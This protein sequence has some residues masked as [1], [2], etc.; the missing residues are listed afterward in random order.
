MERKLAAILAA[1]VVGYSRMIREDEETT[2]ATLAAHR[3]VFDALIAQ[4]NGRIFNTAG[5]SV[6]AEFA[7]PVEAVRCALAVQE[8]LATRNED[9]DENRKMWFRMGVNLGDV[10][11]N[12]DDLLGDGVNI[13]ARLESLSEPGGVCISNS[14]REQIESKLSFAFKD[15][16][17]QKVKNIPQPV[18]AY[19]MTLAAATLPAGGRTSGKRLAA[20]VGAGAVLAAIAALGLWWTLDDRPKTGIARFDGI[21]QGE[22]HCE[23]TRKLGPITRFFVARINQGDLAIDEGRPGMLGHYSVRG[24]LD[25]QGNVTAKGGGIGPIGNYDVVFSGSIQGDTLNVEAI[26]NNFRKCKAALKRKPE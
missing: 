2:I 8:A 19:Q 7:S 24:V 9:L 22:Y 11:I 26:H 17:D 16:G 14:V 20:I 13:A 10:L 4:H 3:A 12:G 23:A 21:W 15:L 18:R 6:L 5:D 1:D 25:D